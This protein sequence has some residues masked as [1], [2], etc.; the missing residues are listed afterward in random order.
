MKRTKKIKREDG[1]IKWKKVGKGS[2][3]FKGRIIKP[4]QTFMARP[5][6][7]SETFRDVIHPLDELPEEVDSPSSVPSAYTLKARAS[8]GYFDVI[9]G[10]GK[11]VNEKALRR[12]AALKLIKTLE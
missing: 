12:E 6:E 11:V 10:K 8:G 9:D 4:G 3:R 2:H 5:D 7:I 1:S